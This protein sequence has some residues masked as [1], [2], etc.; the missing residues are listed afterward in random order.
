MRTMKFEDLD[1]ETKAAFE[2]SFKRNRK[3]LEALAKK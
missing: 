1:E 3:A 2:A